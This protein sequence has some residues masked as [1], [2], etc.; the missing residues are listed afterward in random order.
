ML[1][2]I[3]LETIGG[4]ETY[5][6]AKAEHYIKTY[7][8]HVGENMEN[9]SVFINTLSLILSQGVKNETKL[10]LFIRVSSKCVLHWFQC[11]SVVLA[12]SNL[13]NKCFK[14]TIRRQS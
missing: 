8:Q 5:T 7:L 6:V 2:T 9:W 3:F 11:F 4:I 13:S 1:S 14:I 10:K 12:L